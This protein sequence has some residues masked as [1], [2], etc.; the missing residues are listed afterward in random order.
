MA[1]DINNPIDR[2]EGIS[3]EEFQRDYMRPQRPCVIPNF[4]GEDAVFYTQWTIPYF[5]EVLGDIQVGVY[6]S[7]ESTR[8]D[9]RSYKKTSDFMRFGDY[10]ELLEAGPTSKRLFLFNIFKHMPALK[11]DFRFPKITPGVVRSLPLVFFGGTGAH[12]RIH[13]DMD[14]S[15]VF[16]TELQ[17]RKKVIVFD[18]Q[19]SD[20]LY[21]LPFGVHSSVDILNPDYE[22][23]PGLEK[24]K[25]YSTTLGPRDTIFMPS[26]WW[27]D[28]HYLEPSIGMAMRSLGTVKQKMEGLYYV[29]LLTHLDDLF[30]KV[31]GEAWYKT[32]VNIANKRAERALIKENASQ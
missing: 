26:G 4:Y 14:M 6:D 21:R 11:K 12:T 31:S 30:R 1:L 27:H 18:P 16:L 8:K 24:V 7:E 25:G 23:F 3:R 9:D 5:K 15:N 22:R 29:G 17:G 19:Y 10:L 13:Q 28:I 32:K 2:V 20:L